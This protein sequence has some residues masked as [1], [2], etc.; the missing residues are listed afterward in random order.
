MVKEV[1]AQ[2]VEQKVTDTNMRVHSCTGT[3]LH[4]STSIQTCTHVH[5]QAGIDARTCTHKLMYTCA[6]IQMHTCDCTRKTPWRYMEH[7]LGLLPGQWQRACCFLGPLA[8]PA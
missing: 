5:R 7:Q 4:S 8:L 1:G 6:R 3:H 2:P